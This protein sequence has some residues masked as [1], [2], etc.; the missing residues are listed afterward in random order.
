MPT[1]NS[2]AELISMLDNPD[3]ANLYALGSFLCLISFAKSNETM[4]EAL[5]HY[6]RVRASC[7][8]DDVQMLYNFWDRLR[9]WS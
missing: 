2:K 9:N 1:P 3:P 8:H 5:D 7:Y 4:P 6:K